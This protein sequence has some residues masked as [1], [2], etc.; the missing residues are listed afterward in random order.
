[1]IEHK[2]ESFWWDFEGRAIFVVGGLLDED[3][4]AGE[5]REFINESPIGSFT[6]MGSTRG[7]V[8]LAFEQEFAQWVRCGEATA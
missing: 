1:M 7:A 2:G 3:S 4:F 8:S 5:V 6:M